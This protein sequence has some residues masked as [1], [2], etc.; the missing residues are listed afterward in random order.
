[1]E[2]QLETPDV[3]EATPGPTLLVSTGDVVQL[4]LGE[5]G[6]GSES[7]QYEYN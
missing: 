2:N 7:K 6:T 4:T 5:G 3:I 1:M